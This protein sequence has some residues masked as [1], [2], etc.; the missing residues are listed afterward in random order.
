MNIYCQLLPTQNQTSEWSFT[1]SGINTFAEE[2]LRLDYSI[3]AT[4]NR[5]TLTAAMKRMFKNRYKDA[6]HKILVGVLC[7]KVINNVLYLGSK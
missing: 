5:R 4:C 7:G 2:D 3:G 6:Y 1:I